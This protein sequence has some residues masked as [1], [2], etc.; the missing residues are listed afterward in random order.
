[1]PVY[2]AGTRG[3]TA[4]RFLNDGL[5]DYGWFS[6]ALCGTFPNIA[7]CLASLVPAPKCQSLHL[8]KV[9]SHIFRYPCVVY[10]SQLPLSYPSSTVSVGPKPRGRCEPGSVSQ[11]ALAVRRR[12]V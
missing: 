8:P 1:M 4:A 9:L 7:G 10:C 11:L 5:L 6:P 3:H 2:Q 12:S